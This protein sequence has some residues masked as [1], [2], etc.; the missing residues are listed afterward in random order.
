MQLGRVARWF[1]SSSRIVRLESWRYGCRSISAYAIDCKSAGQFPESTICQSH[2]YYSRAT[3]HHKASHCQHSRKIAEELVQGQLGNA[4]TIVVDKEGSLPGTYG[5]SARPHMPK[6][7]DHNILYGLP[8]PFYD[9]HD[10][11]FFRRIKKIFLP[12]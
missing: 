6:E 3:T 11:K 1:S 10:T 7:Y 5:I 4:R 2:T 12:A 9:M 8:G